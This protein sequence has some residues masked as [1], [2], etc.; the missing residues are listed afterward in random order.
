MI[1]VIMEDAHLVGTVARE[2]FK[3]HGRAAAAVLIE[4]AEI[5]AGLGDAESAQSWRDI[6]QS[7]QRLIR[8]HPS[9]VKHAMRRTRIAAPA[10]HRAA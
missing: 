9:Q 5:A 6:A 10:V 4:Q 8:A 7:A 3:R 1:W 2:F